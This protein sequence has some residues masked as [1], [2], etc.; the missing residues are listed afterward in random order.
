VLWC[1]EG[2]VGSLHDEPGIACLQE[3]GAAIYLQAISAG[4]LGVMEWLWKQGIDWEAKAYIL[5]AKE[6][7]L[8]ILQW[9]RSKRNACMWDSNTCNAAVEA[10]ATDVLEWLQAQSPPC[11]W[12]EK[13][14]KLTLTTNM[15]ITD[16]MLKQEDFDRGFQLSKQALQ[17][18]SILNSSRQ[19]TSW[20]AAMDLH[21]VG[22]Q[23]VSS[24]N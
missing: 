13:T 1:Q 11:P 17:C 16:R 23:N 5:A 19:R 15:S 6:R 20:G 7:R 3:I 18:L 2:P 22:T 24:D 12:N 10:K 4:D 14:L 9:M 21:Q 8:D